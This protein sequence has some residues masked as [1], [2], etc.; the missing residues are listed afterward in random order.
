MVACVVRICYEGYRLLQPSCR[1]I[2]PV[3]PCKGSVDQRT[4]QD[5]LHRGRGLAILTVLGHPVS[6]DDYS[7]KPSFRY[8]GFSESTFVLC[9]AVRTAR[10]IGYTG[11]STST[12]LISQN[13]GSANVFLNHRF[14]YSIKKLSP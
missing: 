11:L 2:C 5:F 10:S 14:W 9:S 8:T 12:H 7:R 1:R 3:Q 6:G 13:R 4:T